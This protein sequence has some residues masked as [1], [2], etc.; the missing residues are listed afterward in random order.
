MDIWSLGCVIYE[1]VAKHVPF[2]NGRDI[3]RFC[4]NR[5]S[6]PALSLEGKLTTN[7]INFLQ[8]ILVAKPLARPTAEVAWQHPWFLSDDEFVDS[9]S[10]QTSESQDKDGPSALVKAQK[11]KMGDTIL[12]SASEDCTIH[13]WNLPHKM[14]DKELI[15]IFDG[16]QVQSIEMLLRQPKHGQAVGY[17]FIELSSPIQAERAA[18]ELSGKDILGHFVYILQLASKMELSKGRAEVNARYGIDES[19]REDLGK[20][21][22]GIKNKNAVAGG[23]GNFDWL[24]DSSY[25]KMLRQIVQRGP[26]MLESIL[27]LI[28]IINPRLARYI[29]QHSHEFLQFLR[30]E[31]DDWPLPLLSTTMTQTHLKPPEIPYSQA[32]NRSKHPQSTSR[33]PVIF[34]NIDPPD[35]PTP[36]RQVGEK[37]VLRKC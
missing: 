33:C 10:E 4:D 13:I 2:S 9:P 19:T 21:Q 35:P 5:I 1:V 36:R 24:T 12:P 6:F 31:A 34:S 23:F 3:K 8:C 30:E 37:M 14:T 15:D 25:F 26:H 18:I 29:A 11:E 27:R 32:Y 20:V 28:G 7:G 22:E 16:Y 17:A